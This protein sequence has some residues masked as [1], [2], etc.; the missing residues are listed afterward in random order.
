MVDHLNDIPQ[1]LVRPA[2]GAILVIVSA[3]DNGPLNAVL[4]GILGGAV[5]GGVH[6]AKAS[7]RPALTVTTGG[8]GNPLVS[9][10][11]DAIAGT[12]AILALFAPLATLATLPVLLLMLLVG[13]RL[14]RRRSRLSTPT[15]FPA[16][17]R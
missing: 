13:V 8:L 11:E 10:V 15:G 14:V 17:R 7:A 9:L 1:S 5:A 12:V 2:A 16:L 6:I 4:A 3:S